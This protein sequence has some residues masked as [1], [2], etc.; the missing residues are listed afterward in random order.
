MTPVVLQW[1]RGLQG[2]SGVMALGIGRELTRLGVRTEIAYVDAAGPSAWGTTRR[3]HGELERAPFPVWQAPTIEHVRR[4]AAILN[5][6][7]VFFH[8]WD[9]VDA[10]CSRVGNVPHLAYVHTAQL[11]DL[12]GY[13]AYVF[14]S[15]FQIT[16]VPAPK[17]ALVRVVRNGVDIRSILAC[18]PAPRAQG[19]LRIVRVSGLNAEKVSL[20]YARLLVRL[21]RADRELVFVGDGPGRIWLEEYLRDRNADNCRFLGD[22]DFAE[23][24]GW[25]KS[26][27]LCLY[28]TGAHVENHSL[29]L[30]E[31]LACGVPIVCENRGGLAEQVETWRTGVVGNSPDELQEAVD[32]LDRDRALLARLRANCLAEASRHD[33]RFVVEDLLRLIGSLVKT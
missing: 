5:P 23:T 19:H 2:G 27:D 22:L 10:Q 32:V 20:D 13:D 9:P 33:I 3:S 30:L 28:M 15:Q 24:I 11:P 8:L 29:S 18:A 6:D 16:S 31:A 25:L 1:I 4:R 7:V 21:A 14:V 12:K 26:S 17:D